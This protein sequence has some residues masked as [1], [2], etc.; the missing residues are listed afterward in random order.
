MLMAGAYSLEY[1]FDGNKTYFGR[2]PNL[3][4]WA[5][6]VNVKLR[7]MR[8][9]TSHLTNNVFSSMDMGPGTRLMMELIPSMVLYSRMRKQQEPTDIIRS[10][11]MDI[12]FAKI[13]EI[14][15]EN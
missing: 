14:D 12:E 3:N 8:V 5:S 6:V 2:R 7:R 9:E 1:L 13:R 4:G 11:K 10:Q 15:K